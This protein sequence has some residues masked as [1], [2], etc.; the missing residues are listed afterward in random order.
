MKKPSSS[1]TLRRAIAS[2]DAVAH[3][4]IAPVSPTLPTV[5]PVSPLPE[6]RAW[7]LGMAKRF[8]GLSIMPSPAQKDSKR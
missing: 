2:L 5:P 3:V 4:V 8:I 7:R 1:A 6:L